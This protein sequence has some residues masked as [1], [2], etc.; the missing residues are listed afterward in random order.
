MRTGGEDSHSR[1]TLSLTH[2]RH[3]LRVPRLSHHLAGVSSLLT[4]PTVQL[5]G[6]VLMI[7]S[8]VHRDNTVSAL[9]E[10]ES[11]HSHSYP[12]RTTPTRFA[13]R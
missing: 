3:A 5:T 4:D 13:S 10:L 11:S 7:P 8:G 2:A 6:V 9:T 12:P 1:V